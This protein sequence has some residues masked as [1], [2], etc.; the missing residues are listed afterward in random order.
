MA[1]S[2]LSDQMSGME[3]TSTLW[4]SQVEYS[5]ERFGVNLQVSSWTMVLSV[6]SDQP[7]MIELPSTFGRCQ[8][9]YSDDRFGVSLS[10]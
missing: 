2:E 10:G 3:L 7:Q 4:R 9:E 6:L 5:D 1:L 8:V